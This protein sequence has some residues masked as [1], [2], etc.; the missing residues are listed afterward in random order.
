MWYVGALGVVLVASSV[1][2]YILLAHSLYDRLDARL[3][4][5]L[6][7]ATAALKHTAFR[8]AEP[9]QTV[10]Q[11]LEGLRF[12][13]QTIAVLNAGGRVITQRTAPGGPSLR[14]PPSPFNPSE[15][16]RFYELT[17]S[18][19]DSDDS[20]R[21]VFQRVTNASTAASYAVVVMQSL[22]PLSDQLD[23]L[24]GFL[25]IVVPLSL[26]LA[27][28]GGW[29]LAR[30]S[31]APV[32]MMAEQAQRISVQNLDQRLP[33]ANPG[34]ELGRLAATFNELLSRLGNSFAQQRQ[35]MADA[36]HE[37]RTPLSH[38]NCCYGNAAKGGSREKRVP[39][40]SHDSRTTRAPLNAYR[41]GHVCA[42]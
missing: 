19:P 5:T 8:Q 15:T 12:P 28:L 1:G 4:S 13:N 3:G 23:L 9:S 35:F 38:A 16:I 10:T 42:G 36:S 37:L 31:L 39:G 27:G 25:Y 30:K 33:V 24:L 32:M 34:D 18:Q 29:L 41:R 20:C 26:G 11:A 7:A 17:E 2:I 6:Q 14:L 40:G 21:G 22:E